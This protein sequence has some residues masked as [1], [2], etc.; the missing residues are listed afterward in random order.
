M[1]SGWFVS[2]SFRLCTQL[3]PA[4]QM[5][6]SSCYPTLCITSLFLMSPPFPPIYLAP[7]FHSF[8]VR[9][10][11]RLDTQYIN[12][13]GTRNGLVPTKRDS[14]HV[15]PSSGDDTD[16]QTISGVYVPLGCSTEHILY[17]SHCL[18]L[19]QWHLLRATL[20][21]QSYLQSRN[22]TIFIALHIHR[23]NT[24]TYRRVHK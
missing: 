24:P 20:V 10:D 12:I 9:H 7:Q 17:Q 3:L 23:V 5:L 4:P 1:Y 21:F 22:M 2:L 15:H 18:V 14:F 8:S 11:P 13:S 6:T 16:L 19:R